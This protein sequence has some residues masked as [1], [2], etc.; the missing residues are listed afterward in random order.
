MNTLNRNCICCNKPL[1]GRMD[2]RFCDDYCRNHFH[3]AIKSPENNLMRNVNNALTKNRRI[4]K[5][6]YQSTPPPHQ[7]PVEDLM[8]EGYVFRYH[9]HFLNEEPKGYGCY[10]YGVLLQPPGM[11]T[12]VQCEGTRIKKENSFSISLHN[13]AQP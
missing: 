9:T 2:K 10:D 1:K 7:V 4:L 11:C 5:N 6:T 8:Q 12:I 13:G 3:N